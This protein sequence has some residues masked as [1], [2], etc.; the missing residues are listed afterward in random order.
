MEAYKSICV[1]LALCQFLETFACRKIDHNDM[2]K[3]FQQILVKKITNL[4][5]N[6]RSVHSFVCW[7]FGVCSSMLHYLIPRSVSVF[8]LSPSP[9]Q[10]VGSWVPP[11]HF[12]FTKE[13]TWSWNAGACTIPVFLPNWQAFVKIATICTV[14]LRFMECAGKLFETIQ[15]LRVFVWTLDLAL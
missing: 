11:T 10:V 4:F 1:Q 3:T 9:I 15:I 14:T 8:E 12:V 5:L 13:V 2:S 6:S 7:P